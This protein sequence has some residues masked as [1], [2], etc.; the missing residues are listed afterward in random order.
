MDDVKQIK[1]DLERLIA[2]A[3]KENKWLFC[4]YQ[5]LWFTPDELEK[6]NQKG[7]FLWGTAN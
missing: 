7:N 6:E 3:R 1:A 5:Q 2:K 4:G